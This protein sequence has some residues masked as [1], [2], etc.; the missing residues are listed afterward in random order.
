MVEVAAEDLL[1]VDE[2]ELEVSGV[3]EAE[4]Q[5]VALLLLDAAEDEAEVLLLLDAVED[6]DLLVDEEDLA[7]VEADGDL[8]DGTGEDLVGVGLAEDG[9]GDVAG[10]VTGDGDVAGGLVHQLEYGHGD[11]DHLKLTLHTT[12]D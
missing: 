1:V 9:D 11:T 5:G 12:R 4:D 6:E 8:Q 2:E 3:A 10:G 7:E